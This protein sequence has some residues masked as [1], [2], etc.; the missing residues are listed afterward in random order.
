ML[1]QM[2]KNSYFTKLLLK[3]I[4]DSIPYETIV[5]DDRDPPW[6]NQEIKK[7]KVAATDKKYFARS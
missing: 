6:I 4:H 5:F 7:I 1:T 3:T 2:K